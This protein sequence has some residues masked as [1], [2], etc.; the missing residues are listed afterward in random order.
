M[1][2]NF[3]NIEH[4]FYTI[5]ECYNLIEYYKSGFSIR[6]QIDKREG[7]KIHASA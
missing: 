7:I 3:C 5:S 2:S 6:N 4:S 1:V